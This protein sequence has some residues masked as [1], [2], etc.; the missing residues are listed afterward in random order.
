MPIYDEATT[1]SSTFPHNN[2]SPLVPPHLLDALKQRA[3]VLN[4]T[5]LNTPSTPHLPPPASH[6]TT[7][8]HA[9]VDA[10]QSVAEVLYNVSPLSNVSEAASAVREDGRTP[11]SRPLLPPGLQER[12]TEARR[13]VAAVEPSGLRRAQAAWASAAQ[14]FRSRRPSSRTDRIQRQ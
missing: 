5:Q 8:Y 14:R 6:G 7:P 11:G 12:I 3:T 9:S 2:A 13:N 10:R 4:G 1:P